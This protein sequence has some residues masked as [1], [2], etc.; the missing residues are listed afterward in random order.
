MGV[1]DE[2]AVAEAGRGGDHDE[3]GPAESDGAE[4]LTV[5]L[6]DPG[7]C[8]WSFFLNSDTA[9]GFIFMLLSSFIRGIFSFYHS[10]VRVI[11]VLSPPS[12]SKVTWVDDHFTDDIQMRQYRCPK[13]GTSADIIDILSTSPY[14]AT[15]KGG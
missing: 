8:T 6:A 4:K 14:V 10:P 11:R 13:W 1:W 7:N 2:A 3:G 5:K 9:D 15:C 12:R